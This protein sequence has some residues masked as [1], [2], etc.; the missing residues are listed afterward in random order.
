MIDN[1]K[2]DFEK[3]LAHT[4]EKQILLEEISKEIE[5]YGAKSL[6]DIG[7]GNGLLSV[8]LSKKVENYLAIE[9]NK[10]FATKLREAKLEVIEGVFP[11]EIPGAFDMALASHSISYEKDSFEPFIKEAW[12]SVKS[13]GVLLIITYRGQEDDWTRLMKDLGESHEDHNRIG[14]NQIIELLASLGKVKTRK[15]ITRV[16]TDNLEDMIQALSFVASDGK[17][18]KKE[19]FLENHLRLGKILSEKYQ[20]KNG[21]FFPFQHFFI[22]TEKSG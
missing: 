4:D 11:L 9:S 2:N 3:F 21:Y 16:K 13:R 1:Y 12:K 22:I 18:E 17:P 19:K 20:D 14:F 8:P 5:K 15:V 6:L 7:A 10:G